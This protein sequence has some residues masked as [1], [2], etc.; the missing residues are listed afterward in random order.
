MHLLGRRLRFAFTHPGRIG[1]AN[2]NAFRAEQTGNGLTPWLFPCCY[3]ERV[4]LCFQLFRGL[5]N[6]FYVKF[7]PGGGSWQIGWPFVHTET[8]LS[9]L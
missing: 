7:E 8:R 4:A 6:I 2:Q 5:C 9:C 3:Q 1:Q